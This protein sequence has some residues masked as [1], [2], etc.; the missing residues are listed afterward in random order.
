MDYSYPHDRY[1]SQGGVDNKKI[2]DMNVYLI[3]SGRS[4]FLK[5]PYQE[6]IW[7]N[8]GDFENQTNHFRFGMGRSRREE[9]EI[10]AFHARTNWHQSVNI[11]QL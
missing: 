7:M 8:P 4:R 10:E 6:R 11:R 1:V 5:I 9:A 3:L 2:D